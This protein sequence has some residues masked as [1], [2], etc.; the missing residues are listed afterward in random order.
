MTN[1]KE[2]LNKLLKACGVEGINVLEYDNTQPDGID[3]SG[4]D[5]FWDMAGDIA[6]EILPTGYT[7]EDG[8][9]LDKNADVLQ[10][11]LYNLLCWYKD[12]KE[13]QND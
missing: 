11:L 9:N 3:E 7:N 6:F 2:H 8:H 10:S 4:S 13:E 12:E 1:K 5:G